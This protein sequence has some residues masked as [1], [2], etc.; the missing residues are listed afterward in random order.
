[1]HVVAE[2]A[3]RACLVERVLERVLR[4]GV[5]AA[6]VEVAPFA[7]GRVGGDRHRLDQR[8]RVELHDHAVLE[9]SRLRLVGVADEVVR[10]HRL[11]RDGL[12]LD[13]GREGGA[14]APLQL[15]VLQLADDALR[16]ELDRA[17]QGL[18]AA[19]RAV[20]VQR[21]RRR[22]RRARKQAQGRVTRLR[23]DGDGA[24]TR[25]GA[26]EHLEH[27]R[28]RRRRDRPLVRRLAR[29]ADERGGS[30]VA[31]AEARAPV[32]RGRAVG[33]ELALAAEALLELR[34]QLVGAVAAAGDVLAD[35]DDPRRAAARRRA[36]RRRS[37]RRTHPRAGS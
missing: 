27:A 3:A 23:Q 11:P 16:A 30:A 28:R 10:A 5:L 35:V 37:R 14:A 15:R 19:A 13:A 22:P 1:M 34:D 6:D 2:E 33:R 26:L 8:E 21:S 9:R 24:V 31:L 29:I 32:P 18:V 36:S 12:P 20:V 17:P 4:L 25:V 7:P